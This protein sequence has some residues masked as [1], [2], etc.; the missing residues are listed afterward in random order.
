MHLFWVPIQHL[1]CL[2]AMLSLTLFEH[3]LVLLLLLI[4]CSIIILII[5]VLLRFLLG[6]GAIK[7]MNLRPGATLRRRREVRPTTYALCL[8]P[9]HFDFTLVVLLELSH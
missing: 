7:R 5:Y 9:S 2:S 3:L 8:A 1:N 4:Y 6:M